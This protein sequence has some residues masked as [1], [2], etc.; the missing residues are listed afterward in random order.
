MISQNGIEEGWSDREAQKASIPG[1]VAL[2]LCMRGS[3][4]SSNY[5]NR[6]AIFRPLAMERSVYRAPE[7]FYPPSSIPGE[8]RP[9]LP[10]ERGSSSR[11]PG[12][13][14]NSPLMGSAASSHHHAVGVFLPSLFGPAGLFADLR[15]FCPRIDP[16]GAVYSPTFHS[17]VNIDRKSPLR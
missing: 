17:K 14:W 12:A 1:N 10:G 6:E 16:G 2:A 7:I 11:S 8:F 13:V 3:L 5:G 4:I 9:A 15:P